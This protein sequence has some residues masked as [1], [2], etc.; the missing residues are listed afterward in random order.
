MDSWQRGGI[1]E[2][3]TWKSGSAPVPI[4]RA[5][6]T[7]WLKQQK[8]VCHSSGGQKSELKRPLGL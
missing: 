5:Q 6:Q 3:C 4:C 7:R 2:K 1:D 8:F